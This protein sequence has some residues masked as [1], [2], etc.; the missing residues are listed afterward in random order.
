MYGDV[1]L[2]IAIIVVLYVACCT[3]WI[4]EGKAWSYAF[5][6]DRREKEEEPPKTPP[7]F[8]SYKL[9][10]P[11]PTTCK[12]GVGYWAS[13]PRVSQHLKASPA[14]RQ[15]QTEKLRGSPEKA[16]QQ[17]EIFKRQKELNKRKKEE[18]RLSSKTQQIKTEGGNSYSS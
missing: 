9:K 18:E 13:N 4:R 15:T 10:V 6:N 14:S 12:L 11:L 16:K 5:K 2:T 7:K 1:I 8:Q 3:G 17:T